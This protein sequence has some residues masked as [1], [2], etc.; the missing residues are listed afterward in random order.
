L[1]NGNGGLVG[2]GGRGDTRG[3]VTKVER[4]AQNLT[5]SNTHGIVDEETMNKEREE[6][7]NSPKK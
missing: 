1:K 5:N 6:Y 4:R 2:D 7:E 3:G